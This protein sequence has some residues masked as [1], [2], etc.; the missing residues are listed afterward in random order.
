M[1]CYLSI[2]ST[3]RA[4]RIGQLL[5]LS[6]T[7]CHEL[8][9]IGKAIRLLTPPVILF[10]MGKVGSASLTATLKQ[11][12][13]GLVVHA[14][15]RDSVPHEVMTL[16]NLRRAMGLPAYVICPIR[17][18]LG[19]NVSAFF[20]NWERDTGLSFESKEWSVE[21]VEKL[22]LRCCRHE[23]FPEF[24]DRQFRPFTGIDVFAKDFPVTRKW[25]TYQ[26][27]GLRALIYRSDLPRAGQLSIISAFLSLQPPLSSFLERNVGE[28]KPYATTYQKFKATGVLPEEYIRSQ[29]ESR[30]CRHFWSKDEIDQFAAAWSADRF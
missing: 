13:K 29:C 11:V 1:M 20:E 16:L 10:Q 25:Q 18:P 8:S 23:V 4:G 17:E 15:Y 9:M 21:E 5:M 27:R 22:F 19:R 3:Q 30:T 7:G 24:F 2:A 6:P 26:H 28:A 14:H 12:W